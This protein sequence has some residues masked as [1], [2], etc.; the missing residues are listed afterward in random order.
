MQTELTGNSI[1]SWHD[2][3]HRPFV[4]ALTE[5]IAL[6]RLLSIILAA[7][8][9]WLFVFVWHQFYVRRS[10]AAQETSWVQHSSAETPAPDTPANGENLVRVEPTGSQPLRPTQ[11]NG[12]L[13]QLATADHP[14]VYAMVSSAVVAPAV[15]RDDQRRNDQRPLGRIRPCQACQPPNAG[16]GCAHCG[17]GCNHCGGGAAPC[18]GCGPKVITGVDSA[19]CVPFGEPT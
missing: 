19:T 8:L 10:T 3:W 2:K 9:A 12:Q 18:L 16:G 6:R 4:A 15:Y 17:G 14:P 11:P 7:L 5:H 1:D 13:D